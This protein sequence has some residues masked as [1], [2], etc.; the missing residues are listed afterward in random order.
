MPSIQIN[1]TQGKRFAASAYSGAG[2]GW[3]DD[4]PNFDTNPKNFRTGQSVVPPEQK[5]RA[6]A[7]SRILLKWGFIQFDR[8]PEEMK[9]ILYL[10]QMQREEELGTVPA[11]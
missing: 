8:L 7:I 2:A 9:N 3:D 10:E 11:R 5:E 1:P 6:L 4:D